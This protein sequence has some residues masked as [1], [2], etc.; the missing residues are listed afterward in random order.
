[1]QDAG[2][3]CRVN[4]PNAPSSTGS[5][6]SP[7]RRPSVTSSTP[8]TPAPTALALQQL[9]GGFSRE[10]QGFR[11]ALIEYA[12]LMELELDFGEEDVEFADRDGYRRH[13][14]ELLGRI[15]ELL[16][17]FSTEGPL[18]KAFLLPSSGPRTA[19][20]RPC[21]TPC[22]AKS[23]PSCPTPRAPPGTPS[24]RS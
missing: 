18:P 23:A 3:H 16:R 6:T 4:S 24:K 1:M 10:I 17:G 14:G 9:G 19:A 21:S 22:S 15:D 5:A 2:P 11:D 12:A 20:N 7:N 8:T 13:V